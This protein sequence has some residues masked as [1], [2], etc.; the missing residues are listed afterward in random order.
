MLSVSNL[1]NLATNCLSDSI[2]DIIAEN[3]RRLKSIHVEYNPL[4]GTEYC[5]EIKRKELVLKDAPIKLQYIPVEMEDELVVRV[6]RKTGTL[7]AA[8]SAIYGGAKT[9]AKTTRVWVQFLKCR[10]KHDFEF[11]CATQIIIRLKGGGRRDNFILNRAQR[12][13]LQT[14]ERLRKSGQPIDIILLK[15]RQWGGSTLTQFYMFW[16]QKMWRTDWNSVICGAVEK[17]SK[18]VLSMLEHAAKDYDTLIDDGKPTLLKPSGRM[19][20][21]RE[22]VGR[23]CTISVNSAEKPENIRGEDI[24]MAH[25]TEIGIWK[26]TPTKSPEDIVQSIQGSILSGA[27]TLY[28]LESTAKGVG[29]YFH[30]TWLEAVEHKN[31]LTPVFVPWFLIDIYQSNI[32]NYEEFI[33]SLSAYEKKLFEFGATLEAIAWYRA[34]SKRIRDDSRMRS[35]YP[36]TPLE[37]F[38]S[39]GSLYFPNEYTDELYKDCCDPIFVGDIVGAADKGVNALDNVRLEKIEKGNLKVWIDVDKSKEILNRYLVTVDLGKGHSSSAD[40]SIIC[41]FDRYWQT[42]ATGVP[43]VAAEWAGHLDM[44]LLSWKA[45]QLAHYYNDALLV[46]ENN[47]LIMSGIDYF[48]G[49]LVEIKDYYPNIWKRTVANKIDPSGRA[50][51]GW[52]TNGESKPRILMNLKSCIREG[53]YIE[54]NKAAVD[55]MKVFEEK[56]SGELGAVE[57]CHDDR[58]ITRAI[59]VTF[60]YDRNLMAAPQVFEKD[61]SQAAY[62]KEIVNEF[63]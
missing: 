57:G 21:V 2:K 53:L 33:I 3:E 7:A 6:L 50:R 45:A 56:E 16:I 1:Y 40:N 4:V 35:E 38:Q 13:Y 17:H 41:V 11:W 23:N 15:A 60:M 29:N 46:I 9:N 34:E 52:N 25:V 54:H 39:T 51:Y 61:K 48:M 22:I 42:E 8:G 43:E 49:V 30:R 44:D 5:E 20:N 18:V 24:S 59:G 27:Y 12:F 36:S 26:A 14:L 28:V 63:S 55:E 47:S 32:E 62:S 31:N 37:A 58:V 10:C 19:N